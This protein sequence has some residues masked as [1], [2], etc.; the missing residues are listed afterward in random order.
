V[1]AGRHSTAQVREGQHEGR[2]RAAYEEAPL[3][4]KTA[5]RHDVG[6]PPFGLTIRSPLT[7]IYFCRLRMMKPK[8]A[9][10]QAAGVSN[11]PLG[12]IRVD[13]RGAVGLVEGGNLF[14]L[15][16]RKPLRRS[17]ERCELVEINNVCASGNWSLTR[18]PGGLGGLGRSRASRRS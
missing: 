1:A 4:S 13:G 18:T 12:A 6:K 7:T 11:K 10:M 8:S 15:L 9:G 2:L 5:A 17:A 16:E 3:K 14:L